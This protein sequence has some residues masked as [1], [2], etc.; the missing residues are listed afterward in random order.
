MPWGYGQKQRAAAQAA[1]LFHSTNIT[2]TDPPVFALSLWPNRSLGR[3]GLR[4]T[5]L[6]VAVGLLIPV[7]PILA[8]PVGLAL[9]PFIGGVFLAMWFAFRR[10]YADARLT[11]HLYLWPD[12][13]AVERHELNG[14][15]KHWQTN[16]YWLRMNITPDGGPVENYLTLR[17]SDR[18]IEL[19]AFL[20]PEERVTLRNDIEKAVRDLGQNRGV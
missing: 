15:V 14:D 20:S 13:I 8:T 11:E 7:L 5:M 12:M 9:L 17:G 2:R 19:G 3:L 1:A 6:L 16:P 10:S 18:E 4:N